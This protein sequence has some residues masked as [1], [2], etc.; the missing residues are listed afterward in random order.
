M[1]RI[2]EVGYHL[3][4]SRQSHFISHCGIIPVALQVLVANSAAVA[5][6]SA[7]CRVCEVGYHVVQPAV[8][9]SL[10]SLH[11]SCYC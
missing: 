10:S 4:Y 9:F 2:C 3:V 6:V 5:P 7:E 1:P 11:H 8:A